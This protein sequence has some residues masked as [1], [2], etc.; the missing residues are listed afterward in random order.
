MAASILPLTHSQVQV[1]Q[2]EIVAVYRSAFTPPPYNKPETEIAGFAGSFLSQFD[3]DGYRFVAAIEGDTG[4]LVGFAY[5]Y[6]SRAGRW[7]YE[8]A[9]RIL[10][11]LTGTSWLE[12]SFQLVEIALHPQFQGQGI[13]GM[14]HDHLLAGIQH[15][16]AILATLHADTAAFRLYRS[17]GWVVLG[18]N[19]LFP[20]IPRRYQVMGLELS[21]GRA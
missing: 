20:G 17:R 15:P 9:S 19:L 21:T 7:W 1:R 5:G 2:N 11:Q 18:E 10:P 13:G 12:D 8:H 16:R 3:R 4:Q 14:L 6:S